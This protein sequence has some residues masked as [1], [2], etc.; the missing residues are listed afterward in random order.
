MGSA[1][2]RAFTIF[3]G[4]GDLRGIGS[5]ASMMAMGSS[6][7]RRGAVT[8]AVIAVD[9]AMGLGFIASIMAIVI[10]ASGYLGRAMAV[11]FRA[12]LM[13]A[14]TLGSSGAG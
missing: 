4:V 1:V 11:A 6:G 10:P 14:V 8:A 12:A 5:M 2:G 7:G 3:L 13:E 9:F